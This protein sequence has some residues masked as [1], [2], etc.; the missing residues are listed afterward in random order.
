MRYHY[1]FATK[2]KFLLLLFNSL[3]VWVSFS[4]NS[5]IMENKPQKVFIKNEGQ[6]PVEKSQL[7]Q[8]EVKYA[9][10]GKNEYYYFSPQGVVMEFYKIEK[11]IKTEKEKAWRKERKEQGF[12]TAEEFKDFER[13]GHRLS[14]E[15]EVLAAEWVGCNTNATIEPSLKVDN[16]YSYSFY[17]KSHTSK[18]NKNFIAAYQ[19]ITYKNLYPNIDVEYIIHPETGIKYSL[20][21]HPGADITQVKLRYSEKPLLNPDGTITTA[22]QNGKVI[23]H[24]PFSFYNDNND[25]IT[26]NY[27]VAG[28]IISFEISNYD[29]S[30][31]IT[32]DPWTQSPAFVRDWEC[33]WECERDAAGNVYLIGGTWK[34][35][36]LKY[37]AAGALQ[38]THVT[39]YD[40][41]SWLGTFAVDDAGNSYVTLGSVAEIE[42][43]NA[44]GGVVWSNTSP[45]GLFSS[46]EFWNISFNCDQTKLIVGGTGGTLP[47]LP[48]IYDIDM[49]SGNITASKQVT[50]GALI[51]T[52]EVRA[53]TACGNAKYYFLTHD[54]IGYIH[55]NLNNCSTSSLPFHVSNG[56]GLGYKCENWRLNNT[57]IEAI[58]YHNGFVYVHKGNE[59]Q[60]RNFNTGAV[61]A[62]AA[63]PGGV[64]NSGFGGNSLGCSGIGIDSCGNIFVGSVNQIVKYNTNLT[65]L[66]TYPTSTNYNVYDVEVSTNGD[67]IACG[68]T[69]NSSSGARQGYIQSFALGAC[70]SIAPICCDATICPVAAKCISDAAFSLVVS[71][72]G[73][74]WSGNG[75]NSTGV[76]NPATAGV[77]VHT[78]I[79]TLACGADSIK[80][81]VNSCSALS[82]CKETNGNLTVLG[83]T[84]PYTWSYWQA[85]TAVTVTNAA[86][87]AACGGTWSFGLCLNGIIPINSCTTPATWVA[88]GNGTTI[89]P[90]AGK[91]TIR[92]VDNAGTTYVI[93]GIGT[94]PPCSSCALAIS[95]SSVNTS[96]GKNNGSITITAT[97]TTGTVTYTWSP[98][99][100]ATNTASGLAAGTYRFTVSDGSGASCQKIDS[101]VI[102]NSSAINLTVAAQANPSCNAGNNGS[103]ST[104]I[105]GATGAVNYSWTPNIS[106]TSSAANLAANTYTIIATD[107][108]NCKDTVSVILSQPTAI[109]ITDTKSNPSCGLNNGSITLTVSGGVAGYSYVW[110]PNVA[111]TSSATNLSAG[112]YNITVTDGNN[113]PKTYSVNLSTS[114]GIA[115][116]STKT[117]VKC[118]GGNDGKIKL[119]ISGASGNV[120]YSWNPNVST[121]DSAVNLTSGIYNVTAT[122]AAGCTATAAV[123]IAQ[124]TAIVYSVNTTNPSCGAN[125]GAIS[126]NA[127]GGIGVLTYS[128]SP[129]VS[130]TNTASNLSV[131]IYQ[132]TIRD[133]NNCIKVANVSLSNV[134]G[135]AVNIASQTNVDCYGS[136][137]G[138]AILSASG[139]T[140]TLSYTWSS[141]VSTTNTA[142]GLT[143]GNYAVTVMDGNG[144]AA[145]IN[146]AI[147]QQ[148]SITITL[149]AVNASCGQSNGSITATAIGGNGGYN[150]VWSNLQTGNTI[151]N[152]AAGNYAVTAT[153]S[154]GCTAVK[155]VTVSQSAAPP[156]PV[157]SAAV[158]SMC[159]GDSVILSSSSPIGNHWSNGD[160]AA[161]ITVKISG[162]YTTYVVLNGCTTAVSNSI[163]VTVNPF[164]VV[165]IVATKNQLCPNDSAVLQV[166]P[167]GAVYQ[168]SNSASGNNITVSQGGVYTVTVNQ[169]GCTTTN[170]ITI[171]DLPEI[172]GFS[173]GMDT[174]TCKGNTI[175][176]SALQQNATVYQWNTGAVNS[177]ITV[178]SDGV[179]IVTV[180]NSCNQKEDT[181]M[182]TFENCDCKMAVPTAFTPNNDGVN[183]IFKPYIFCTNPIDYKFS[184]YNRWGELVFMTNRIDEGW[185]GFYKDNAQPLGVYV[186]FVELNSNVNGQREHI[187]KRGNVTLLR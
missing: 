61:V 49:N 64:W 114:A 129:N 179:Y 15:K 160:T 112:N 147:T 41:S 63:I 60:K 87:C 9:Y 137:T 40:T 187:A 16:Y 69:G 146:I 57:G 159:Q 106:T 77:G 111:T 108:S 103:I 163:T 5:W 101:V 50:N 181:I 134:G 94:V 26:T 98:N 162:T 2:I 13:K 166:S 124:P 130:T 153:D 133:G 82:V 76:F 173:L 65:Q 113:C 157:V 31:T 100:S 121:V 53:I 70:K 85:A 47:P 90:P 62:S 123:T 107:A 110:S 164:P 7:S 67:V 122:D 115:I 150:Y 93:N 183:D 182:V 24:R 23:D 30:K 132:I 68:S 89:T 176:L 171:T 92:V 71:T 174:T 19:K 126:L 74:T 139:G 127:S 151:Q 99:V 4:Q 184:I 80:I 119:N 33:V 37:N 102:A 34:M 20:I 185:D 79:Y 8:E 54:S 175:T 42:K 59:I 58:K 120:T 66:G 18:I 88:F 154:K 72:P 22:L 169:N 83:G 25:E 155:T 35:D 14:I 6:F 118:N 167:A 29:K 95:K 148:D 156:T 75:V 142:N 136:N 168:W 48:F 91:D 73:G 32:I 96:C 135:P 170:S 86:T 21:L 44:S 186:F 180:S 97:N 141:N 138:A 152:L 109:S 125:D 46:M 36:L 17:N 84:G 158:T 11:P 52:Q 55:Q 140:G 78:I 116:N 28:N 172:V 3:F 51:P 105:A 128:W 43:V 104:A 38:W 27:K 161:T 144:C 149:N 56:I 165:T 39:P 143:A 12:A 10:D 117:D 178:N 81:T 177:N 45:G 1:S 131:G 145:T